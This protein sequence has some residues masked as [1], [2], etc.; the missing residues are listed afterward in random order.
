MS[1][2]DA[3]ECCVSVTWNNVNFWFFGEIYSYASGLGTFVS[4]TG[5]P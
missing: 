4:G 3:T 2:V 5:F 1:N